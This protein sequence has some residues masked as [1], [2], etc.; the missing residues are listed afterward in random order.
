M[1]KKKEGTETE[2]RKLLKKEFELGFPRGYKWIWVFVDLLD[3]KLHLYP[4]FFYLLSV[5]SNFFFS[6]PMQRDRKKSVK[7]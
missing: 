6:I 1:K 5:L 3:A 7:T 4:F 2:N